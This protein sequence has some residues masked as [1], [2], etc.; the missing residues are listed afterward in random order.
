MVASWL[1]YASRRVVCFGRVL[2]RDA[3]KAPKAGGKVFA[4]RHLFQ[5]KL[6]T[7]VHTLFT[8]WFSLKRH[9]HNWLMFQRLLRRHLSFDH[10]F[11][12]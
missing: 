4:L 8:A 9:S 7:L 1:G 3:G 11:A 5:R 6:L 2:P 10:H 12:G